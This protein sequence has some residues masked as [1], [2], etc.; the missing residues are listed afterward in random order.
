[1]STT[2]LQRLSEP[3]VYQNSDFTPLQTRTD[4][5]VSRFTEEATSPQTLVSLAGSSL[6]YR[7]T[8]LNL[9]SLA[10]AQQGWVGPLIH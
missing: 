8:R 6:A 5:L 3:E 7:Y 2:V 10:S 9:L 1:M 4:S